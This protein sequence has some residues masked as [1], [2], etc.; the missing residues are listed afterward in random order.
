MAFVYQA[1]TLTVDVVIFRLIDGR[2]NVLLIKRVN[3]PFK[4]SWALPGGYNTAD[5]TTMQVVDRVLR[6]K[7][8]VT[9]D[10]LTYVEQ[11]YTFDTVSRDPRGHAVS[12]TYLGLSNKLAPQP[13]ETTQ[14]PVYFPVAEL[15][16]LAYDHA[17]IIQYA[18]ERLRSKLT[19][20]TI[21]YALMPDAFTLTQLQG[22]YEVILGRM[23]DKRNFRKKFLSFDQLEPTGEYFQDGAHRPALLYRFRRAELQT[24]LRD[25]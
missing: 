12:V 15:P 21:A 23:L 1:P 17:E 24:L 6:T 9:P 11:L 3:E 18:L 13:S 14:D 2:L 20:T 16:E 4:D 10:D 5:D 25:F 19:Y 7:V 22:A 8:G